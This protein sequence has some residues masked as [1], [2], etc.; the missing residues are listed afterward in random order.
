MVI[1]MKNSTN[2]LG[3]IGP[4]AAGKSTIVMKLTDLSP[5]WVAPVTTTRPKR[6][7]E[8]EFEH[9]FVN[10]SEFNEQA[11]R[12]DF[13]EV[14][15]PFGLPHRYGFPKLTHQHNSHDVITVIM[16]RVYFLDKLF[17][18]FPE[19][20]V[21]QIETSLQNA[22]RYITQRSDEELGTRITNFEQ[23]KTLGITKADR[24]YTHDF[25]NTDEVAT[26]IATDIAL[27]FR[28]NST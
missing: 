7:N 12:G 5:I 26:T 9:I 13:L 24:T 20:K 2:V 8:E 21:Y 14:V 4:S 16:L 1:I 18:H 28:L 10:D 15:E 27:D 3:I 19:A 17:T 11:D 22:K 25:K 23:E 6:P